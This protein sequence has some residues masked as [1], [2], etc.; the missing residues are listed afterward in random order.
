MS[1]ILRIIQLCG[2]AGILFAIISGFIAY[3]KGLTPR[4]ILFTKGV[5][6]GLM[7]FYLSM[8]IGFISLLIRVIFE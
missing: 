2:I 3:S 4:R 1:L 5:R 7:V 8:A 6:I